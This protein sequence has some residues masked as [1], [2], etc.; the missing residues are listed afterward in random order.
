MEQAPGT[1]MALSPIGRVAVD[2]SGFAL[3]IDAAF[4]PALHGLDGFSHLQVLFW[5]NGVDEPDLRRV[6]D[7][8]RPYR[9]APAKLGIFATRS[10]VRPN[11]IALT[12]CQVLALDVDG[13]VVRVGFIDAE[14]GTPI[15]DLKPYQPCIDR[16]RD[17]AV[18]SWCAHW[19]HWAEDSGRFDWSSE[20][21]AAR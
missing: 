21:E 17:V 10:P 14:D 4:R 6:L 12:A 11:P 1:A 7:C 5:C 16:V 3:R 15:L 19:P 18:P 8:D 9:K 20:F 13:G 2:E